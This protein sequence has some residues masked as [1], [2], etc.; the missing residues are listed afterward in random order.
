MLKKIFR[1]CQDC[2]APVGLGLDTAGTMGDHRAIH[3]RYFPYDYHRRR[4]NENPAKSAPGF[5]PPLGE[6][7][8]GKREGR[9]CRQS[10]PDQNKKLAGGA[11]R[12]FSGATRRFAPPRRRLPGAPKGLKTQSDAQG[13]TL[14]PLHL[15]RDR[16]LTAGEL[17]QCWTAR[18]H[19]VKVAAFGGTC[20]D[21]DRA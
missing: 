2:S 11:R 9:T 6:G 8:T 5:F 19:P 3:R 18:S 14:R 17:A 21:L 1:G 16:G 13:A 20:L 10:M 15:P 4:L 12:N 7:K